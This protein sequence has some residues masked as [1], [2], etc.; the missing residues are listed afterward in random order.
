MKKRLCMLL[1]LAL[2]VTCLPSLPVSAA[3]SVQE[4]HVSDALVAIVKRLEGFSA[5]P[6]YDYQHYSIGYGSYAG[7]TLEEANANF[8]NG[9][10]EE[11]AEKLLRERI[12]SDYESSVK[13]YAAR[14]GLNFSQQQFDALVSFTY[15]LGSSWTSGSMLA[16]WLETY[17]MEDVLSPE[18]CLALVQAMGAWCRAGSPLECLPGLCRRR[19]DEARIFLYGD[20]TGTASQQYYYVIFYAGTRTENGVVKRNT[21]SNGYADMAAYYIAGKPLGTLPTPNKISGYTFVGWFN[22]DGVQITAQTVM[23]KDMVL[24]ARWK[25][26]SGNTVDS[27]GSVVTSPETTNPG[28]ETTEVKASDVFEDVKAGSWYEDYITFAYNNKLFSGITENTF[29]PEISMTRAM[30]VAVLYRHAGSPAVE[31]R[32]SFEDVPDEGYYVDAVTWA[33]KYG[34]VSGVSE[35]EFAPNAKITREQIAALLYRYCV[36]YCG[37]ESENTASLSGFTDADRVSD[38]AIPALEWAVGN[39]VI[40]GMTPTTLAPRDNATRAQVASMLARAIQNVLE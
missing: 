22:D 17:A 15:N 28:G 30:L 24:T 4:L 33:E 40:S 13:A 29:G 27:E 8:P 16:T 31:G 9:I 25:D 2:L 12:A 19:I 3:D 10:T 5:K 1:A 20:Y 7:D 35:T 11:E 18:Q 23:S 6:Y 32:S 39:D 37:V 36:N 21:M 38:Y 26:A 14:K 34:I